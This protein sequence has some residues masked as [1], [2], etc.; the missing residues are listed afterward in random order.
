MLFRSQ[1]LHSSTENARELGEV[2]KLTF[3]F[4]AMASDALP[5]HE[6]YNDHLNRPYFCDNQHRDTA[7]YVLHRLGRYD[8]DL[9]ETGFATLNK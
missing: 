9:M 1:E 5:E 6:V 8:T 2:M 7:S 3:F 4:V